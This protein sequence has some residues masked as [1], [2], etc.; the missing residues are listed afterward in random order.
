MHGIEKIDVGTARTLELGGNELHD[1]KLYFG[2]P[3]LDM[4]GPDG[5][6]GYTLFAAAF[7]TLDFEHTTLQLQDPRTVDT[8]SVAGVHI[9]VDL[10]NGTPSTVMYVQGK[11]TTVNATLDTGDPRFVLISE[12]LVNKYGLHMSAAGVLGGCGTLDDMSIGPIVYDKPNACTASFGTEHDALLGYDFLKGL[13]KLHFD[14][15]HATLIFT[16]RAK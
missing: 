4:E 2:Q 1:V 10:S 11:S 8:A 15:P 12:D 3:P 14:Y 9:G 13:A 7:T 6:I 16:P 5:L